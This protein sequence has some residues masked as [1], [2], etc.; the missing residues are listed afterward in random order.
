MSNKRKFGLVQ[1]KVSELDKLR[2]ENFDLRETN[3]HLCLIMNIM[4]RKSEDE[5]V[6]ITPFELTAALNGGIKDTQSFVEDDTKCII[7]TWADRPTKLKEKSSLILP[8][9]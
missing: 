9:K 7:M 5:Q 4:I 1:N 2:K 3:Q 8:G 6:V